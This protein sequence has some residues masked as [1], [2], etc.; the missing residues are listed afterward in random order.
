M[1][2]P[3]ESFPQLTTTYSRLVA[4]RFFTYTH[5]GPTSKI[6]ACNKPSE[7]TE[8]M[9]SLFHTA[10]CPI[11]TGFA[12]QQ[13]Q[14]ETCNA[15]RPAQTARRAHIVLQNRK[16]NFTDSTQYKPTFIPHR[17]NFSDWSRFSET[18]WRVFAREITIYKSV[19]SIRSTVRVQWMSRSARSA[20]GR[21]TRPPRMCQTSRVKHE[22]SSSELCQSKL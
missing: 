9:R 4:T 22:S 3:L 11:S 18:V 19:T 5:T 10:Y 7:L 21:P 8:V 15:S 6:T 20:R 2:A 1:K 17:P 16:H 12:F 13:L 14:C